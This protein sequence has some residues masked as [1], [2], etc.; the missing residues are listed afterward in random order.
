M[1]RDEVLFLA[2]E[3]ERAVGSDQGVAE[4]IRRHLVRRLPP[5]DQMR[6][7]VAD[8]MLVKSLDRNFQ[9][10]RFGPHLGFLFEDREGQRFVFPER[11]VRLLDGWLSTHRTVRGLEVAAECLKHIG[12]RPDLE[13]LDRYPIEGNAG[14][15]DRIKSNARFSLR[16]RTLA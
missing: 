1:N 15:V 8:E 10:T 16:K 3:T 14:E 9:E 4:W 2:W 5:E 7:Q 12:T 13:L 6:V 11:Q